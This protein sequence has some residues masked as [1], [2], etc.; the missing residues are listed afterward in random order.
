MSFETT[1]KM[2]NEKYIRNLLLRVFG[3]KAFIDSVDKVR[4]FELDHIV[5]LIDANII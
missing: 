1:Y 5:V 4:K 3:F 2:K